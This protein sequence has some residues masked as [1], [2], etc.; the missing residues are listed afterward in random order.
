MKESIKNLDRKLES[1]Y[2]NLRHRTEASN[3]VFC[4]CIRHGIDPDKFLLD[5]EN[6]SAFDFNSFSKSRS[7]NLLDFLHVDYHPIA[8]MLI[9]ITAGGNGGMAS[10]GRC[11]FFISFLSNFKSRISM[12]VVEISSVMENMKKLNIM[13]VKS[14]LRRRQAMK[15]IV[16]LLNLWSSVR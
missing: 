6:G 7:G 15:Y 9:D 10:I 5:I 16:H 3:G 14:V 12:K 4:A 11:E 13:E 2:S 1:V 8:Q